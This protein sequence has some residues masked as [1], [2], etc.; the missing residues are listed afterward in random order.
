M[1]INTSLC[2][3]IFLLNLFISIIRKPKARN[4]PGGLTNKSMPSPWMNF[5]LNIEPL[6]NISRT[7]PRRRRAKVKPSPIPRP[8]I[9]EV[10][11]LFFEAKASA[12]P[13]TMQ[14]T[15]ISGMKIPSWSYMLGSKWGP[16]VFK[17]AFISKST[18]VTKEAIIT[19]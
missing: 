11:T 10:K 14:L 5:I 13:R 18:I 9:R 17:N 4:A 3:D 7:L 1:L 16:G 12:L 2:Y 6:P 8:S 19:I 15:T